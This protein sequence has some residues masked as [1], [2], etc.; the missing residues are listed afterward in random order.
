[1]YCSECGKQILD[2]SKF[3]SYCGSK[4][5]NKSFNDIDMTVENASVDIRKYEQDVRKGTLIY[6]HDILS[7][8]FS[9]NKLQNEI[10]SRKDTI[11]IHDNWLFGKCFDLQHPIK[12]NYASASCTSGYVE[13]VWLSYS[14]KLNQYYFYFFDRNEKVYF[15][16]YNGRAVKH[17]FGICR[18]SCD[19]AI[20][21]Q[22]TRD[23]LCTMPILEKK[24]LFRT[25]VLIKNWSSI[26]WKGKEVLNESNIDG[27]AEVK[28]CIEQFENLVRKREYDYSEYLPTYEKKTQDIEKELGKAK[29][30]L[31]KLYSLNIIPTK[32]RN[33]GC[34]YF[35]YDFF[36]TSNIPLNNVFLHLDLDKIQSQLDKVISNQQDIILQQAKIIAQNEEIIAQNRQLF[37][38]LS[39]M[40]KSVNSK[41]S[42]IHE[43]SIETS[44]WAEMAAL[45][46][47]ACTWIGLA[48]YFK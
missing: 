27:I 44:Q 1:M 46:A 8:E 4:I 30:I 28:R 18:G 32:Y 15:V 41:L 9:I 19:Y 47:E 20:L 29:S 23:K 34:I 22:K 45:N 14:Y 33:I 2:N 13:K 6:L 10:Q 5:D 36:S 42:S 48:N 12:L 31:T 39:T 16:D 3:C 38:E 37:D 43:T 17:K 7:M 24:G 25:Q 35:I 11:I 26:Y 40:G 21:D